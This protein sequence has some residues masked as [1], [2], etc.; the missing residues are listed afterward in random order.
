MEGIDA[1]LPPEMAKKAEEMG[2]RKASLDA[3]RTL[4]LGKARELG[5]THHAR[6]G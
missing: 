2:V 4:A 1:L 3:G 6:R 5:Q